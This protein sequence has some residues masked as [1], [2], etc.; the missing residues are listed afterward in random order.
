MHRATGKRQAQREQKH[1]GP[2]PAQIDPQIGEIHLGFGPGC[3]GLRNETLLNSPDRSRRS[4]SGAEVED[5][6]VWG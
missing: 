3:V 4:V 1:L 2:D 5:R 6:C